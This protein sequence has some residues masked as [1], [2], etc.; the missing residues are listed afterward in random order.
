MMTMTGSRDPGAGGQGPEWKKEPFD[1]SPAG[2]KYHVFIDGAHHGSFIG[3]LAA[4]PPQR[5]QLRAQA[6]AGGGADQKAVFSYVQI[7][8]LAF[9]DAYLKSDEKAKAYLQS[10]ALESYSDGSAKLYRK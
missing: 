8:T 7:A 3:G 2:D 10:D 4:D 9:W 6:G 5:A 1:F